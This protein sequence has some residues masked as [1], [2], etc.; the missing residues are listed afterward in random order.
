MDPTVIIA[1]GGPTGLMLACELALANVPTVVIEKLLDPTGESRGMGLHA[2]TIETL[3]Q[4]GLAQ[5]LD[6]APV[7]PRAHFA[8]M[9]MDLSAFD[10]TYTYIVP[11]WRTEKL[12]E[13]R[14]RELGVEVRR[15]QTVVAA[16]QDDA[17]VSVEVTDADG[18]RYELRG[19][20]LVGADGGSSTVRKL[21]G[22]DFPGTESTFHGVLGDVEEFE[23]VDGVEATLHP[24]GM[25]AEIPLGPDVLRLMTT[26][27]DKPLPPEDQEVTL[28]ELRA[29]IT[30]VTGVD[31]KIG[32]PRWLSR[33]GNA[34]RLVT[35][36]RKGR[37]FLVGDAAHV[38]YPMGGQGLN[39]GI[40]DAVNLGWK[41]AAEINGWAPPGLLDSYHTERHPVAA[42]VGENTEAQVALL[43]P[44]EKIGP[45]RDLFLKLLEFEDVRRYLI[46]MVTGISVNYDLE[47]PDRASEPHPLEGRRVPSVPLVTADGETTV[48]EALH[49]GHGVLLDLS[50]G[51]AELGELSPW[52]DRVDLVEA[53]PTDKI[54][55][56]VALV[57]PDGY[58]A[59]AHKDG[60]DTEGLHLALKTWFG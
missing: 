30:A 37:I 6:D 22:F 2:R 51:T 29:S 4:R 9:W 56:A 18:E 47:Y 26:E 54:E 33:F 27:F 1:G 3:D 19:A 44:L 31:R 59:Y 35:E 60:S 32:K 15:G 46:E 43:H 55:A 12:L 50:G 16:E 21:A 10:T 40:Q 34:N 14:A 8:L 20:Y 39:T 17:G 13:E 57:R 7:W 24:N 58:V 36:Y 49:T 52:A 25:Y 48:A 11:Q 53:Q 45:L 41:L 28:D 5:R 42:R 23:P 38:H